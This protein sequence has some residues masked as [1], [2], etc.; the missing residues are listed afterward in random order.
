[1][2]YPIW[3]P[4]PKCWF[5]ALLLGL[6]VIPIAFTISALS[7][8]GVISFSL[9]PHDRMEIWTAV[10]GAMISLIAPVFILS[11]IHQFLWGKS[12]PKFPKLI[13]SLTS[14]AAGIWDWLVLLGCAVFA[15]LLILGLPFNRTYNGLSDT[16]LNLMMMTWFISSAYCYHIR[17][18]IARLFLSKKRNI[19]K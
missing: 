8:M 18:L 17:F 15:A 1:M 14:L 3:F 5:Q 10:L 19:Y 4:Y 13:P 9:L 2:R 7:G 6:S 16:Q 11:H 12:N